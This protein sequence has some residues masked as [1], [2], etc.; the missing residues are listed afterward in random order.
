MKKIVV[1]IE[2][3]IHKQVKIKAA[4]N[5]ETMKEYINC[6]IK[7]DLQAKKEQTQ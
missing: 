2:D 1:E 6:L 7:K 3:A 4:S 5:D